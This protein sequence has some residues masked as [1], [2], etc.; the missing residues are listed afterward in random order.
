MVEVKGTTSNGNEERDDRVAFVFLSYRGDQM[1][2][3]TI[4]GRCDRMTTTPAV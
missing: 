2:V 1:H 3:N 4:R